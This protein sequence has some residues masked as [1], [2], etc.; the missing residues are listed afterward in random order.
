[1]STSSQTFGLHSRDSLARDRQHK[2]GF[3]RLR[4]NSLRSTP[5]HCARVSARSSF[6]QSSAAPPETEH[7]QHARDAMPSSSSVDP[8]PAAA[9]AEYFPST[10]RTQAEVDAVCRMHGVDPA[11]FTAPPA[12]ADQRASSPPPPSSVCV[13]ADALEAGMRVPLHAFFSGAPA[14]F[15]LAPTQ[16][17]PNG[18]RIMA[19]FV[20]VCRHAGLPPSLA[21][22]R[23][24]FALCKRSSGWYFFRSKKSSG[25][26]FAGTRCANMDMDWKT[27]F[28]FLSS[29][30]PWPCP[31]EWVVPS[32][33]SFKDPMLT[34]EE[35]GWAAKL[36][37]AHGGAAI[38][39]RTYLCETNLAAAMVTA[40]LLPMPSSARAA[41]SFSSR[42]MD[43]SV[44]DTMEKMT[45]EPGLAGAWWSSS[46]GLC[47]KKRSLQEANGEES[48]SLSVPNTPP[49]ADGF[50]AP[51]D[52][53]YRVYAL[54]LGERL[55]ARCA[56]VAALRKKLGPEL[57]KLKAEVSTARQLVGTE[58][59]NAKSELAR[60][61]RP[62]WT[63]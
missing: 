45:T 55:V 60:R 16:L 9:A 42:G 27:R 20:V 47:G 18:W 2:V 63:K 6:S 56:E 19:G 17:S 21:V 34:P 36:L 53:S 32:E 29:P 23:T 11:L 38:D 50:S 59:E 24:F 54:E 43:S 51:P 14:H 31:V 5:F 3:I 57:E 7:K 52:F 35:K 61:R 40:A 28:F 44:Y 4:T 39:F 12:G 8:E 49:A 26:R 41:A 22:F 1:M 58:L 48:M 37:L 33:T 62:C 10:L 46:L 25:L 13:Y 30:A 15:G